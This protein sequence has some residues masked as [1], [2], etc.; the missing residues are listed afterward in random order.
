MRDR[1]TPCQREFVELRFGI[2]TLWYRKA[3]DRLNVARAIYSGAIV[4][5]GFL[6]SAI[7]AVDL[8]TGKSLPVTSAVI[9]G[10]GVVVGVLGA[11]G[12][13]VVRAQLIER[14]RR[15][16]NRL[17]REAWL[18]ATRQSPYTDQDPTVAFKLFVAKVEQ[19]ESEAIATDV[20]ITNET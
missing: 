9:I 1:V 20:D 18:F 4:A 3:V 12:P 10:L 19:I 14:Y 6:I 7:T 15:G 17:R 8:P 16:M 11:V 2:R 5:G 13:Q